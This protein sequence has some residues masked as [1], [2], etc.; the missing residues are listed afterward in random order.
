MAFLLWSIVVCFYIYFGLLY[1]SIPQ[2]T[3]LGAMSM[4]GA[5]YDL[6]EVFLT[7]YVATLISYILFRNCRTLNSDILTNDY[8]MRF[9][10]K[11]YLLVSCFLFIW[12]IQYYGGY[13]G[14]LKTPYT[15]IFSGNAENEIKD[16][17]IS[18][19]GLLAIFSILSVFSAGSFKW[20]DKILVFFAAII[21]MSIFIQGRRETLLLMIMCFLSYKFL[22]K[23]FAL[24]NILKAA[25]VA[26]CLIVFAGLGLY[27]RASSDT[28]GGSI[29]DASL[30]AV[31]YETHFTIANL[32][33]EIKTHVYNSVPF[34]G[35][36]YL[37]Y[38]ILF[39][40]PSFLF[41][42]FGYNKSEVFAITE[43]KIYDD[44]GGSFIFT[45]AFHSLGTLGVFLHGL[46][47]GMLLIYFYRM[48][49]KNNMVFY[50]FP[51]VALILVA[52]RKDITYGIKYISLQF[53]F[54]FVFYILYS[55]LPKKRK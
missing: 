33:N 55:I 19:S 39:I 47:L 29:V 43:P 25:G 36:V 11:C 42:V 32:A 23:K 5:S 27:L 31:L 28:S 46:F 8:F 48:A 16:V 9:C 7:G 44:K 51:L 22:G 37:L 4:P 13:I 45:S 3:P 14:F 15:A 20:K 34:G 1:L 38:P 12:G 30:Y 10:S 40:F 6:V 26:A 49:K 41:S 2:L 52:S 35:V 17:L 24:V 18:S 54:M 53:I 21:L 50:H